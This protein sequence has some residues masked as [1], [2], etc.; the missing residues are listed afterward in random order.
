[1]LLYSDN[2]D[3]CAVA[4]LSD[5]NLRWAKVFDVGANHNG[6]G[7]NNGRQV[8]RVVASSLHTGNLLNLAFTGSAAGL[9][10]TPRRYVKCAVST[11]NTNAAHSIGAAFSWARTDLTSESVPII[12]WNAG[13]D[14]Y[15]AFP[16][17]AI[18]TL[19][20]DTA[21]LL[22]SDGTFTVAG[23]TSSYGLPEDTFAYIEVTIDPSDGS[24]TVFAN[25]TQIL[26]A[27][28]SGVTDVTRLSFMIAANAIDSKYTMSMNFDDIMITD[29][30]GAD[31]NARTGPVRI[32]RLPLLAEDTVTFTP[33]GVGTNI[34]AV[35]K[36][37]LSTSTYNRS[38]G[39]NDVGDTFTVD[40]SGLDPDQTILG[41][42]V[43]SFAARSD[44]GNRGLNNIATDGTTTKR[45]S[46]GTLL[47][48]YVGAATPLVL[49][50][51]F[52][53]LAWNVDKLDAAK[54]GYEVTA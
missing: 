14:V 34:A 51:G 36:T 11:V 49:A 35:N 19:W 38:G 52:D 15:D 3:G 17:G 50:N 23:V 42:V 33:Q 25:D 43:N 53:D 47:T 31:F 40:T 7:N 4:P 30:T 12:A 13:V 5:D 28:P 20:A 45:Q 22:N 21:L 39:T 18:S 24:V 54:F 41:V 9:G 46:M 1:M 6:N 26:T 8:Y 37:G 10:G 32:T 29:S 27:S 2:I 16:A 44:L 48:E